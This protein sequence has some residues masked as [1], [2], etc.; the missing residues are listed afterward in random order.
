MSKPDVEVSV[1]ISITNACYQCQLLQDLCVECEDNRTA[2]DA[3]IAHQIVDEGNLI[4]PKVWFNLTEPSGHDWVSA[5]TRLPKPA[6]MLD[7]S[8]KWDRQEFTEPTTSLVDRLFNLEDSITLANYESVCQDCHLVI[9][10]NAI[11]PN[12]N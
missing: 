9:N 7:G 12:C 10:S 1:G 2:K 11:C 4:Y 6:R 3:D 5:V 8:L